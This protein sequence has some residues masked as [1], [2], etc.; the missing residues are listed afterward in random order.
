MDPV[1]AIPWPL[2]DPVAMCVDPRKMTLRRTVC[3]RAGRS[4]ARTMDAFTMWTMRLSPRSGTGPGIQEWWEEAAKRLRRIRNLR[5]SS[6]N[7]VFG[8]E[9]EIAI[10][11]FVLPYPYGLNGGVVGICGI[12]PG[13]GFH[14]LWRLSSKGSPVARLTKRNRASSP[15][16]WIHVED[17]AIFSMMI[18]YE[19]TAFI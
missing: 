8:I 10:F 14:P 4:V 1:V 11:I 7:K 17:I 6:S 15:S 5:F 2:L 9:I 19:M 18:F 13:R 3:R 16:R 12:D